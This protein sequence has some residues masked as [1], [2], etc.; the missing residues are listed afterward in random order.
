M[1]RLLYLGEVV[2]MKV[3]SAEEETARDLAHSREGTGQDLMS[4]RHRL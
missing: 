1:S 2:A 4:A 3:P